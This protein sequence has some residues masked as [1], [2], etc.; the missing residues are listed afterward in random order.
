MRV[1]RGRGER[2][3]HAVLAEAA[4]RSASTRVPGTTT[5]EAAPPNRPRTSPKQRAPGTKTRSPTRNCAV[6]VRRCDDAAD[7]FVTG[8]QRIAHAGERRHAARP[9][10]PLGAGA[11]AAP[12]DVDDD[13]V[14]ARRRQV[15]DGS[16]ASFS[17]LSS[18]TASVFIGRSSQ[19]AC[20]AAIATWTI[21]CVSLSVTVVRCQVVVNI[22][23]TSARAMANDQPGLQRHP[24]RHERRDRAKPARACSAAISA[25][26]ARAALPHR[27]Q[28]EAEIGVADRA[29]RPAPRRSARRRAACRRAAAR[30]T[31]RR[32]A[33]AHARRRGRAA[34]ARASTTSAPAGSGSAEK[35]PPCTVTRCAKPVGREPRAR[36]LG[37][38]RQ[39]EHDRTRAPARARATDATNVPSPPPTSSRRR[40]RPKSDRRRGCPRPPAAATTTSAPNT[41]QRARR[42]ARP[43]A[44]P[45]A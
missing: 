35:S 4:P 32:A 10:Q 24:R 7:R 11:D 41:R 34:R 22:R 12:V 27:Q 6:A 26:R 28:V 15:A 17:G 30:A 5:R 42:R 18:T 1:I 21:A 16:S 13:V 33:R 43:T 40:W 20:A 29:R 8:H 19:T 38:G 36:A 31:L 44:S 9:E 39:V 14:V 3:Q 2:E 25:R 23:R 45:P 37:D